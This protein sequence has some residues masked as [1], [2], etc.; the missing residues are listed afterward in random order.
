MTTYKELFGKYVQNYTS[1]PTSTDAEG[2][3]WYNTTTGTFRTL[4]GG[5]G[6]WSSGGNLPG[7]GN[8]LLTGFGTQTDAAQAGG[9]YTSILSSSANYNGSTWTASGTI[10]TGRFALAGAG[11]RSSGV[12]FGGGNSAPFNSQTE[13]YN[14]STW[15]AS[16]TLNT[17]RG[18]LAG[19]GTQTA[20]L[21]FGGYT[22]SSTGATEKFNGSAWTSVNSMNTARN[23]LAGAG[24]QTAALAFGGSPSST[25]SYNGTSWTSLNNL[26]TPRFGLAGSISGTN[27]AAL[28]F[29][30]YTTT[31]SGATE[32][33]NGTS[34]TNTASMATAR[35]GL[36]GA[37]TQT[38]ALAFGGANGPV[39]GVLTEAFNGPTT[40]TIPATG[41]WSSGGNLI[42]LLRLQASF[43]TQNAAVSAG[44]SLN[45]PTT[46]VTEKYNGTSWT[47]SGAL[48]TARQWTPGGAGTQTAGLV[49]GGSTAGSL[50]TITGATEKYNGTTWTN[51]PTSMN[52]ARGYTSGCGTQTAALCIGG[53]TVPNAPTGATESFNGTSWTTLPA[54][55]NTSRARIGSVGTQT[56]ALAMGSNGPTNNTESYNGSV[57]TSV[58]P[59]NSAKQ[60]LG[61]AGTQT[62]ALKFGGQPITSLTEVWNGTSWTSNPTGLATPRFQLGGCGDSNS[63]ALAIGGSDASF[64]ALNATEEFTGT[65]ATLN[66]KTLTTS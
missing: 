35:N 1:D 18:Y 56:A 59:M 14:G 25:E 55:M 52:T 6:V 10:N 41:T 32:S 5:Y 3:I 45:G 47:A 20:G 57:W 4:F 62:A 49:F 23:S 29:G 42:N 58:N 16:G 60:Y 30:G 64:I 22:G 48:N 24:T 27:T 54:V 38:T 43:G 44:G 9:F 51:N 65:A 15:T 40:I 7:S 39:G 13:L 19:T 53:L 61:V 36:A 66:Y 26:N 33:Y 8:R 50:P 21:A 31:F 46:G 17:A 2:Q 34:W 11:T 28:A 37:G 12:I 63:Q